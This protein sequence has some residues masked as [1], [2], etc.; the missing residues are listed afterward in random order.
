MASGARFKDF[1]GK[2]S[3][4]FKEFGAKRGGRAPAAP[5]PLWIRACQ[6][7]TF[8]KKAFHYVCKLNLQDQYLIYTI[9]KRSLSSIITNY[10]NR[11]THV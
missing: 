11:R 5:P 7:Q 10:E 3:G 1:F 8:C 4:L 9:G 2:F 6:Q